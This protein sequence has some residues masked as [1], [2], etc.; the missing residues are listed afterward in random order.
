MEQSIEEKDYMFLDKNGNKVNKD[1]WV[2]ISGH[3]NPSVNGTDYV[4]L[5]MWQLG[6]EERVECLKDVNGIVKHVVVNISL[7]EKQL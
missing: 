3:E 6:S 5:R 2:D 4:C 1:D 7:V